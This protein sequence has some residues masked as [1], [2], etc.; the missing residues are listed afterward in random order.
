VIEVWSH[1]SFACMAQ[2]STF[3]PVGGGILIDALSKFGDRFSS[4]NGELD[5]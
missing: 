4:P 5:F 2:H 1:P 3:Y